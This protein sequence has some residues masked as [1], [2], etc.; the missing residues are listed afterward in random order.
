MKS[1]F[2]INKSR[3]EEGPP[4][5]L[6]DR[7]QA[8]LSEA[9]ADCQIATSS[10]VEESDA[11]IDQAL[12]SGVEALWVG[13]GDGTLNHALNRTF[14]RNIAYGVVPMGT[15]NALANAIGIP[16]EPEAAVRYLLNARPV[17]TD[18]GRLR[19]NGK[20]HYFFTYATVG[21]H[22]AVFHN[23]DTNLK[24]RWGKLAFWESGIRTLWQKSR[25]PRFRM[26][27]TLPTPSGGTS[28]APAY[29]QERGYAFTLSNLSNFSG[30]GVF[31]N[32]KPASPGYFSMHSFRR[33]QVAPMFAWYMLL[34]LFG[35]DKP[36]PDRGIDIRQVNSVFVRSRHRLSVQIDGE[37]VQPRARQLQFDCLQGK[38]QLLLQPQEA[39]NLTN[40]SPAP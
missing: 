24:Q 35:I 8:I 15:V 27:L 5:E 13:G 2:I 18:V 1:L 10:S 16:P 38:I 25:L 26:F 34:R 7:F 32:K 28:T 17:S 14:G 19:Q 22:A 23:I 39:A 11:L 21:I 33:N 3:R 4:P 12:L 20:N 6:L 40:T 31:T 30:F 9:G 37:P 36:R 29:L